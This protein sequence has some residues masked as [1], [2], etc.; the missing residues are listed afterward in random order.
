MAAKAKAQ[1]KVKVVRVKAKRA[2]A[3]KNPAHEL[4]RQVDELHEKLMVE[5]ER[6]CN[7]MLRV[8]QPTSTLFSAGPFPLEVPLP[9]YFYDS[10]GSIKRL[11]DKSVGS[12]Q[13]IYSNAGTRRASH[14]HR[15]DSHLCFIVKGRIRY[16]ERPVGSTAPPTETVFAEGHQFFTGPNMEHEML[17]PEETIFVVL[18]NQHRT[19]EEYEKDVVRLEKP[20]EEQLAPPT[21]VPAA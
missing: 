20:L 13:V 6:S 17:F 10:R 3:A 21:P 1:V 11:T 14:W 18:A 19:P 15:N 8:T 4:M 5:L 12:V 9:G 7:F 2:P 16:L